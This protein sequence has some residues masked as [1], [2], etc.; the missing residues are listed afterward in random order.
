M[1]VEVTQRRLMPPWI[2]GPGSEHRF[3][4][5]RWLTNREQQLLKAWVDGGAVYGDQADLPPNP[6]FADGWQ[7]GEPDLIVEMSDE[8]HV[9]ADGPDLLQNFVIPI[10]IPEDK[11]VAAVEFHPG[12]RRVVHHAVLFLDDKGQ[13]RKLDAATPSP[14]MVTLAAPDFCRAEHWAA[15]LSE[16]LRDGFPRDGA[17]PQKGQ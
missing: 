6:Q 13:A 17:I 14:V 11:L 12:N 7:L 5:E 15:G 2:P 9:P 1:I 4:G 16:I 8:F 3:V 10:Q